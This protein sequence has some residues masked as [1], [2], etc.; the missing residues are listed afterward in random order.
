MMLVSYF[1]LFW[2]SCR[3]EKCQFVFLLTGKVFEADRK[4]VA[5]HSNL[6][7]LHK[8][9]FKEESYP[10][11]SNVSEANFQLFL[12]YLTKRTNLKLSLRICVTSPN[13]R[14]SSGSRSSSYTAALA[15]AGDSG[16]AMSGADLQRLDDLE[17]RIRDLSNAFLDHQVNVE[18]LSMENSRISSFQTEI[19]EFRFI[20][21][22]SQDLCKRTSDNTATIVKKRTDD[23]E[24]LKHDI[25]SL[26]SSTKDD[27]TELKSELNS[28]IEAINTH[29]TEIQNH[30][31][32][33][34]AERVGKSSQE[35][36]EQINKVETSVNGLA[37]RH[38]YLPRYHPAGFDGL[39][40]SLARYGRNFHVDG[41]VEITASSSPDTAKNAVDLGGPLCMDL[42]W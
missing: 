29:V 41:V 7:D 23:I 25:D 1:E 11:Q 34:I 38:Y 28:S 16:G 10:I 14:S 13:W 32:N 5:I 30:Q 12:D 17:T 21:T 33:D 18:S 24:S 22:S 15:S 35:L 42:R 27:Q 19:N 20:V 3:F 36:Q 2:D 26:R 37:N 31:E 4:M 40:R 39:I 9:V 6:C 8:G